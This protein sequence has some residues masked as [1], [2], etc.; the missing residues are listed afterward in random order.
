MFNC[1]LCPSEEWTTTG[2]CSICHQIKDYVDKKSS[3]EVLEILAEYERI[4]EVSNEITNFDMVIDEFPTR[5]LLLFG[6]E[7]DEEKY[8]LRSKRKKTYSSACKGEKNV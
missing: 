6:E 8:N 7:I 2:L 1:Y 3:K 4:T 5:E